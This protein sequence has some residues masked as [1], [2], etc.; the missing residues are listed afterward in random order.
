M[1][2]SE[3]QPTITRERI[4]Q[5][6]RTVSDPEMGLSI[7]EL[8]LVYGIDVRGGTVTVTMTLTVPG[9]P[10]HDLMPEWV[11]AAVRQVPGVEHVDVTLTFD[12][13]WTPDRMGRGDLATAPS[14]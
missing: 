8:G 5:A 6:L 9:C 13:P 3:H 7:V 2:A 4:T 12:P 10:I 11:R 1:S 14:D